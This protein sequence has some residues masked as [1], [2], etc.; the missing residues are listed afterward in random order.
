MLIETALTTYSHEAGLQ[1][2][3]GEPE[4]V[5]RQRGSYEAMAFSKFSVL[6]GK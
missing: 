5:G 2:V 6:E 4:W 3:R 1:V